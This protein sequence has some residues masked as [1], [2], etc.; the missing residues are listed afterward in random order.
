M[1]RRVQTL[2]R[3]IVPSIKEDAALAGI[4]DEQAECVARVT[5]E[6]LKSLS[7]EELI[8]AITS[9]TPQAPDAVKAAIVEQGSSECGVDAA[10][11]EQSLENNP[12]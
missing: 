1:G 7:D 12:A 6:T 3:Q 11:L 4:T 8:A 9:G 5:I 2:P 10:A